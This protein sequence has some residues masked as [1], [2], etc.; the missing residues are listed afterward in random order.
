VRLTLSGRQLVDEGVI[1]VAHGA[2]CVEG[3]SIIRCKRKALPDAHGQIGICHK[4]TSEGHGNGDAGFNGGFRGFRLEAK[5]Y[6]RKWLQPLF[7]FM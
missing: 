3:I 7:L 6:R 4:V 2:E 1:V 5:L